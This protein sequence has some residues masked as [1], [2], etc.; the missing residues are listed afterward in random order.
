LLFESCQH[1]SG[2]PGAPTYQQLHSAWQPGWQCSFLQLLF[3]Y[4]VCLVQIWRTVQKNKMST[5]R[6]QKELWVH[7]RHTK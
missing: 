5:Y 3:L 4:C 7:D 2:G 6:E 1:G